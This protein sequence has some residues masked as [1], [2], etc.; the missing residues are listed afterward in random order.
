MMAM[1]TIWGSKTKLTTG[2]HWRWRK[3]YN[4]AIQLDS[5]LVGG[6]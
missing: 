4:R 2:K 5:L 1:I 6:D 3:L